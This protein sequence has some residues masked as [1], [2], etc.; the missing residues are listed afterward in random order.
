MGRSVFNLNFAGSDES[1]LPACGEASDG[2]DA[3]EKTRELKPDAI[4]MDVSMPRMNGLEAA[5]INREQLPQIRI[6]LVSQNDP[7]VVNQLMEQ[8]GAHGY[9]SKDRIARDLI[10]SIEN[11]F[12]DTTRA[13][14]G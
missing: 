8:A 5:R 1:I 2:I 4:L 11:L 14:D 9:V 13:G 3:V 6:L 10:P 7:G 12:P